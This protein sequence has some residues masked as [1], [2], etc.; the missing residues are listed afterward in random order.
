MLTELAKRAQTNR[1]THQPLPEI[2]LVRV[3]VEQHA[4]AFP[5]PGGAPAAGV[6]VTLRAIPVGDDPVGAADLAQLAAVDQIFHFLI[7]RVGPLVIHDAEHHV[8]LPGAGVHLLDLRGVD[9]CWLLTQGMNAVAHRQHRQVRV[10]VMRRGDN[11]R[12]DKPA[13]EH[14]L[15]ITEQRN[16][17]NQ[18][19]NGRMLF[20]RVIAHRRKA[21]VADGSG[22]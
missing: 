18:L 1:H 10:I 19:P 11:D 21:G 13:L 12:I 4:A 9:A 15:R 22:Q 8:A 20:R 7:Q 2:E 16:A 6:V 5:F 17:A 3:L 14:L